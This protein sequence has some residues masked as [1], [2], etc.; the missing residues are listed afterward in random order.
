M[1]A[2]KL[3]KDDKLRSS[4]QHCTQLHPPALCPRTTSQARTFDSLGIE[5]GYHLLDQLISFPSTIAGAFLNT[6]STR[7][8]TKPD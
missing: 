2:G 1:S 8:L 4:H 7:R 3:I 5:R 6:P